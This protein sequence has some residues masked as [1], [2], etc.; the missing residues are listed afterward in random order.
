MLTLEPRPWI[1]ALHSYT[2]HS[3]GC[4]CGWVRCGLCCAM[5]EKL[6]A[7]PRL[8]STARPGAC[9]APA[10]LRALARVRGP[11]A[12]LGRLAAAL[13]EAVQLTVA[14]LPA[15]A[16]SYTH[17]LR[18]LQVALPRDRDR[19][20]SPRLCRRQPSL[21]R[22][23]GN[24]AGRRE[25]RESAVAAG[26][27]TPEHT[28]QCLEQPLRGPPGCPSGFR[29][30]LSL[31]GWPRQP[32]W[33]HSG[34]LSSSVPGERGEERPAPE[35]IASPQPASP[36]PPRY[37]PRREACLVLPWPTPAPLTRWWELRRSQCFVQGA[38]AALW[39]TRAPWSYY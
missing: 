5:C 28:R 33:Q 37:Y 17:A 14:V 3:A 30:P 23:R 22:E 13:G 32:R 4:G 27:T 8:R 9:E 11:R 20:R 6:H 36:V 24:T 10:V 34:P 31:G 25:G 7:L 35:G 38:V 29:L 12:G 1:K 18:A 19:R 15:S 16:S 26:V 39:T 2:Q 21:A